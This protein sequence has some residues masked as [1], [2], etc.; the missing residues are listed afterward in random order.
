V[1]SAPARDEAGRVIVAHWN[2]RTWHRATIGGQVTPRRVVPD[3]AGGVWI[4]AMTLGQTGSRLLHLSRSGQVTQTVLAHG[5]GNAVSDLALIPGGQSLWGTGG[6]L[7]AT[8]GDAAIWR[9]R[10]SR[11]RPA[12][13]A[14]P[15]RLP[16]AGPAADS[17]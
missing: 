3:G 13:P 6:F 1:G 11:E 7:T 16:G 12:G 10:G 5:L 8:G 4:A 15:V 9:H 14:G 17:I 2:G